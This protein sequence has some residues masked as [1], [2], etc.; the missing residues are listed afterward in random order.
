MHPVGKCEEAQE[1]SWSMVQCDTSKL[2]PQI[3]QN[4]GLQLQLY[5]KGLASYIPD[6]NI[7]EE[8]STKHQELLN[9]K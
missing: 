8:A 4:T 7:A 5:T 9:K 6:V 2:L 1:V 3:P